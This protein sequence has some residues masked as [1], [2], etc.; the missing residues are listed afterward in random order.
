MKSHLKN[1]PFSC[2]ICGFKS[3]RK[4]NLKQ[5]VEKRH[6]SSDISLHHLEKMY[7]NMYR[8][9]E[10]ERASER[11]IELCKDVE[12]KLL[13]ERKQIQRYSVEERLL[14][15]RSMERLNLERLEAGKKVEE[16][17]KEQ[18]GK[19]DEEQGGKELGKVQ[20]HKLLETRHINDG[21]ETGD[22][23]L[24]FPT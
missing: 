3:G 14:D 17:K 8:D 15:Q 1:T 13:E 20:I 18:G 5:H 9:Q 2:P 6:C 10:V 12:E 23:D 11:A 22:L 19:K 7:P 16:E 4:D 21:K 24:I